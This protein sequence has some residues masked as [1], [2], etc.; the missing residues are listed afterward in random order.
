MG[1][2]PLEVEKWQLCLNIVVALPPKPPRLDYSYQLLTIVIDPIEN[3]L[4]K[5]IM[6]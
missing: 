5:L 3:G 1:F 6:Q 4:L 2:D